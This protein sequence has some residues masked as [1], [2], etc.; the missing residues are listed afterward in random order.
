MAA[1]KGLVVRI[2]FFD[3]YS[4]ASG[5]MM[6]GALIDAGLSADA[7]RAGLAALPLADYAILVESASQHG[8]SGTRVTVDDSA[9]QPSRDW[10]VIREMIGGSGMGVR[11]KAAALDVFGRL[12]RAEAAVHG[13]P[14]ESVHFHEVGGV[15]S[16]VDICGTCIGLDLLGIEAVFSAPPRV[17]S[18]MVKTAH[19]LLPVPAPATAR[20]LAEAGVPIAAPSALAPEVEA[21]LLT[22]TGAAILATLAEFRRPA[23]TATSTGLGFGRKTLPWPNALR[24]WIGEMAEDAATEPTESGEYLVETNI[25]DMTPQGYDLLCER[26]FAAGAVDVW[27]TPIHMKKGRPATMVSAIVDGTRRHAVE[28]TMIIES[29]TLGVRTQ[30]ISRTKATRRFE[31]VETRWGSLQVKL[32]GWDGRVIDAAPEY[33]DC[34]AIARAHDVPLRE[35]RREAER[36]SD[37]YIGMRISPDGELIAGRQRL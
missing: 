15:D 20:L 11:P 21:E 19:G 14:L 7:L 26:L 29:T 36:L 4:G 25:D 3:P 8:V 6:L 32:R 33:E 22:P 17:G 35:V 10:R 28:R 5:D 24:L 37:G 31:T 2:A 12:A 16:I 23:F 27:L 1:L 13:M 9:D 18:G 34:V 30:A